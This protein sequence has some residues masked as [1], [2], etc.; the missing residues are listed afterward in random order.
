MLSTRSSAPSSQLRKAN[1]FTATPV[2]RNYLTYNRTTDSRVS[3]SGIRCP[4]MDYR[5]ASPDQ[6]GQECIYETANLCTAFHY[7]IGHN[8][9]HDGIFRK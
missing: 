3:T 4:F 7:V 6:Q 9:E 1:S 2:A 5:L 8:G